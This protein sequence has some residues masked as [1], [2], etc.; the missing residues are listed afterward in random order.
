MA[1]YA[2]SS[3]AT[4]KSDVYSMGI[5]LMELVSGRMPTDGSFGED[6]DMV[7][8]IESCIEMSKEEV[9]DPVLKPLLPNEE[10]AALQVLEIALECTKTA[11]AERP[12]SRKVCDLLLHAFNDKVVHSDKMSPDN[13]V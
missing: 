6:M 11:P 9:I 1:E 5:V 10:S 12:S 2:Y 8:W 4:E 3:R 13:Y 7:R